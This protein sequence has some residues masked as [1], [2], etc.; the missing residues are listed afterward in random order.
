MYH[1]SFLEM[2]SFSTGYGKPL[3]IGV[4]MTICLAVAGFFI[5]AFIGIFG[6]WAKLSGG[7]IARS[8]ADAYTTVLRAIPELLVIFL[9]YYGGTA[10][11]SALGKFLNVEGTLGF[12]GF[13]AGSL[14]IGI[15]AGAQHTEVFRGAFNAVHKGEIEA[16]LA[17]GM[18][19]FTRFRRI[20]MP[21]TLR[22]ALPGL[23]NVWQIVLKE[24]A[25]VSAV[26]IIELMRQTQLAAG[27]TG[28]PFNFYMLAAA[29]YLGISTISGFLLQLSERRL[30]R[31]VRR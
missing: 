26:G 30:S 5:G 24:S 13:L 15:C 23:G 9:F 28:M 7:Y 18:S 2:I 10:A 21:L 3:L 29:A 14:A 11:I 27:S 31:G 12:P 8:V 20:I 17:C 6:A 4:A 19:R 22:H 25:L 1:Y 16:A